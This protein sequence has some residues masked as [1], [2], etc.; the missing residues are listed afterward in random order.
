M[1][2]YKFEWSV[3]VRL[4]HYREKAERHN[5]RYTNFTAHTWKDERWP[6]PKAIQKFYPLSHSDDK[7]RL[8]IDDWDKWPG[9]DLGDAYEVT[10]LDN[11]GWFSDNF[12]DGLVKGRVVSLRTPKG[13]RFYPGI[14]Y[15]N[16]EGVTVYMNDYFTGEDGAEEAARRADHYAEKDAEQC[17]EDDAE[18]QAD[19]RIGEL[20]EE[21]HALNK[22]VLDEIKTIKA[23]LD[24]FSIKEKIRDL[25]KSLSVCE[26]RKRLQDEIQEYLDNP[27]RAVY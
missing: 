3:K 9:N 25:I 21:Y 22:S 18:Y 1:K 12:Q 5:E 19:Q 15:T 24:L 8:F 6:T 14:Y 4:A 2:P 27:W 23:Q 7:S 10:R 20:K 17:R 16:C 13:T 11:T 26:E